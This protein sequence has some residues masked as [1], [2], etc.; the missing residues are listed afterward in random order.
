MLAVRQV[1]EFL[2]QR[3]RGG[4]RGLVEMKPTEA[5]E[6]LE[7]LRRLAQLVAEPVGLDV[8]VTH[9]GAARPF[10]A[11]SSSP[12][13]RRSVSSSCIRVGLSGRVASNVSPFR[14]AV[15]ASG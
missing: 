14:R 15:S 9:F 4:Q 5:L 7:A 12:R 2:G 11:I 13:L 6:H 3:A 8:H 10:A 1:G